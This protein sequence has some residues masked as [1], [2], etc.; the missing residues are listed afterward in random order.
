MIVCTVL[1]PS[2][3]LHH[4]EHTNIPTG[5]TIGKG[6][7]SVQIGNKGGC[8]ISL[9]VCDTTLCFVGCHLAARPERI[10]KRE[11]DYRAIISRSCGYLGQSSTELTHQFD[12]VIWSGD[13]NYRV[14]IPFDEVVDLTSQRQWATIAGASSSSMIVAYTRLI[15]WA[16]IAGADQ[17]A[18][19][20]LYSLYQC[21]C[22]PAS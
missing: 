16:T 12:H 21:R 1:I 5:L 17:H 3:T 14:D 9:R 20:T 6:V 22:R 7:A 19:H 2:I 10:K 13:L 8:L 4:A 15:Q 11:D 18:L